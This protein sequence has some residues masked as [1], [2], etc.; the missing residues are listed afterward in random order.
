MAGNQKPSVAGIPVAVLRWGFLVFAA[1]SLVGFLATFLIAQDWGESLRGFTRFNLIWALPAAG[2]TLADWFGGALRIKALLGPQENDIPFLRCMQINVASTAMAYLTPSGA[3]GGPATIY[4]LSRRGLT[5]GRAVALNAVSFLSNVIFLSIAGLIAWASGLGGQIAEVRLPVANLSANAL[6][7]WSAWAFATGVAVVVLLTV[8]PGLAR[9]LIRRILGPEHPRIERV[10]HHFDELH[11][12]L[13]TYWRSGK[14]M[15]LGAILTGVIHFGARFT[16]G[17]VV[18]RG[19][20]P[21]APFVQILLLHILIQY[22][23]FVMPTPSGAGIG[24]VIVAVVMS[25]FLAPG[26]LV[27]YIAVWRVFL[28]YSSVTA[29]S[30]VMLSW[31]GAEALTDR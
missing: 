13:T 30:S 4:G 25:P 23:L 3:G 21:D 6:F 7:R 12:G 26:L 15:F 20:V 14:L 9:A 22:L 18:L 11:E 5:F 16:L 10:L 27:P 31:L 2:L 1:A 19:F 8:L 28:T 29:G 17:W 24:E